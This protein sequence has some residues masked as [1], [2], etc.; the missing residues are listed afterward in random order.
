MIG[1]Y[2]MTVRSAIRSFSTREDLHLPA[3]QY[4]SM[5]TQ[6]RTV[7]L[8]LYKSLTQCE[9][10]QG[11]VS[12]GVSSTG[13]MVFW[14]G[15]WRFWVGI[16][17]AGSKW[18]IDCSSCMSIGD[19]GSTMNID[20]RSNAIIDRLLGELTDNQPGYRQNVWVLTKFCSNQT[21][22]ST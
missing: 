2:R 10:L 11:G 1:R 19:K 6:T 8:Q 12:E 20:V 13:M 17:C 4:Q 5:T 16:V 3:V 22:L 15:G 18:T 21:H 7:R 9:G 14:R